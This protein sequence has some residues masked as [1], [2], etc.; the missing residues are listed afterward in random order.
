MQ[1]KVEDYDPAQHDLWKAL[2]VKQPYADF[3]V[4]EAG[5]VGNYTVGIKQIEVRSR[6][7]QYR[8][9]LLI[10]SSASPIIKGHESGVTLGIVELYDVRPMAD[11]LPEDWATTHIPEKDRA[12][13]A[14]GFG[15]F[16]RNPRRVIEM[17]VKGQLGIFNLCYTKGEIMEYPKHMILDR[18]GYKDICKNR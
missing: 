10:C 14:N 12:K 7:T 5:K 2:S 11:L 4:T 1:Y 9:D 17:P 15:W 8:G 6:N 18:K 3:L 13:Y 16:M